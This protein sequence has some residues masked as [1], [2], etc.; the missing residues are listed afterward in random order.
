[1]TVSGGDRMTRRL[2]REHAAR[3]QAEEIAE[4]R[5]RESF[6][7]QQELDLVARVATLA[8]ASTDLRATYRD[9]L[10]MVVEHG[11]WTSGHVLLPAAD[12]PTVLRSWGLWFHTNPVMGARLEAASRDREFALGEG[13]PG[14]AFRDGPTWEPDFSSSATFVR[15]DALAAGSACAFP[16]VVKSDVVAVFECLSLIPRP[17]DERFLDVCGL[18]GTALGRA[19]ER[20][21]AA[22]LDQAARQTLENAV[23]ERTREL[24]EA[25]R[26]IQASARARQAFHAALSHELGTP[27]HALRAALAGA[28]DASD[29]DLQRL[30]V[31]AEE[32][33]D[34]LQ[35]RAAKLVHN[36]EPELTDEPPQVVEPS[37]I[38]EPTVKA[39]RR[40][41]GDTPRNLSVTIDESADQAVFLDESA[42]IR[43]VEAVLAAA[44]LASDSG[45]ID[46]SVRMSPTDILVETG[47][48][49]TEIEVPELARQ[50]AEN[51]DGQITSAGSEGRTTITLS[52]PGV[53]PAAQRQGAVDRVLLADDTAIMR[54]LGSAM[55]TSLGHPV[56]VV[57]NGAEAV[58]A[59]AD[60][61][62]GL[63][64]M[65]LSM[66][67]LDG[68]E[69]T[70]HIRA[71]KVGPG[72]AATPVVALTAHTSAKHLLRSRLAGM[73]DVLTKSFTKQQL[74]GILDRFLPPSAAS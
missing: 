46:I 7:R 40:I 64:L 58:A 66:P 59:L 50:S 31:I 14:M 2:A 30:L 74:A 11:N 35:D 23:T 21:V 12:D 18:V 24:V 53:L 15:R 47:F 52:I 13:L 69:A 67:E 27:L 41:L 5:L 43:G 20:D 6:A 71:G 32:A 34:E 9:V 26:S 63:V 25:R 60:T 16:V 49:G 73:D 8:N 57:S 36:A 48:P 33:A 45:D 39:Y 70:R 72:A 42:L 65:D 62:Y 1:M 29:D 54:Q 55:V 3:V 19:A 10:P 28:H 22:S 4:S 61:D 17:I 56:D 44:L 37:Q 68:W 51:A 38:L